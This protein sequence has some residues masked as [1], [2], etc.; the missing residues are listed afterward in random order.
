MSAKVSDD[1]EED[2]SSE[3]K[4]SRAKQKEYEKM[5]IREARRRQA[6]KYGEE[7][8]EDEDWSDKNKLKWK[9]GSVWQKK[10]KF[11]LRKP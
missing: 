4:I 6:E 11:L 5:I 8:I 1:D 9:D 3:I 2:G 10:K 7:F